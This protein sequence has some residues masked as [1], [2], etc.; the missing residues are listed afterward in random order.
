VLRRPEAHDVVDAVVFNRVV[1][2]TNRAT[3]QA[4]E[5][6]LISGQRRAALQHS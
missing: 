6:H 3:G 5:L 2:G 4:E 1:S